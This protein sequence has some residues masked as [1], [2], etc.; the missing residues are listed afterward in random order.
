VRADYGEQRLVV[1]GQLNGEV[2]VLVSTERP[3][4]PHIISL[5]T[6]ES[7]EARYYVAEAKRMEG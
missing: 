7:Y 4:G 5:R 6:A 3:S 2:V 1:F